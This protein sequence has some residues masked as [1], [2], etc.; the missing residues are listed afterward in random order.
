MHI[1]I[2]LLRFKTVRRRTSFRLSKLKARDHVVQGMI[3]A[4]NRIDDIIKIMKNSKDAAA[5]RD[6][7]MSAAYGFSLEQVK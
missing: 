5:A 7:L 1:N 2:L 3:L 4:L 6:L